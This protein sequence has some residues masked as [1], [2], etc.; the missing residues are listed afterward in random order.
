MSRSLKGRATDA[1]T[2]WTIAS[3]HAAMGRDVEAIAAARRAVDLQPNEF[4]GHAL[5][6]D[7]LARTNDHDGAAVHYRKGLENYPEPLPRPPKSFMAAFKFITYFFPRLS[8][9]DPNTAV[10]EIEREHQEWF[11]RAK[12]YLSW[13][14]AQRGSTLKPKIQ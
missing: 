13:Y 9:A 8:R 4:T 6:A 14:D 12:D 2:L 11:Y 7:L 1:Y 10:S 3:L 5:L